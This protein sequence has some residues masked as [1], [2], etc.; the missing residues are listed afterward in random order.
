MDKAAKSIRVMMV[1]GNWPPDRCAIGDYASCLIS[2][3]HQGVEFFKITCN[4]FKEMCKALKE[5]ITLKVDITHIQY[6]GLSYY[7][8]LYT[9]LLALLLRC[10]GRKVVVTLHELRRLGRISRAASYILC[11]IVNHVIFTN[12]FER[13]RFLKKFRWKL[14]G[15][16]S[17]V[18]PLA[19]SVSI[20]AQLC[21]Q[22][23]RDPYGV[24]YFGLIRPDKGIEHFIKCAQNPKLKDFHFTVIGAVP[25][26]WHAYCEKLQEEA[27]TAVCWELNHALEKLPELL[28]KFSYAFLPFAEDGISERNTSLLASLASGLVV[29]TTRGMET[30]EDLEKVTVLVALEEFPDKLC[31]VSANSLLRQQILQQAEKFIA[32]R[33]WTD[34]CHMHIATYRTVVQA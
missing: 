28:V 8:K 22:A 29:L 10:S 1:T 15:R 17:S 7:K 6:P 20:D 25:P 23:Q 4:S 18:I 32:C 5:I 2:G 34:I 31:E 24:V 13:T 27:K 19:S 11:F 33:N 12:S 16:K 26:V 21:R 3:D 14:L 30:T 9:H